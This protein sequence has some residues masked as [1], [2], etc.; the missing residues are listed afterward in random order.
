M[1][2]DP[3]SNLFWVHLSNDS[4]LIVNA[5]DYYQNRPWHYL[6]QEF[7]SFFIRVW[8]N[9]DNTLASTLKESFVGII[10]DQNDHYEPINVSNLP[11][12]RPWCNIL[13]IQVFTNKKTPSKGVKYDFWNF[14]SIAINDIINIFHNRHYNKWHTSCMVR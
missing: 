13:M 9:S 1:N 2:N 11:N 7:I 4:L 10:F 14:T 8:M 12:N 6:T 3:L 5:H